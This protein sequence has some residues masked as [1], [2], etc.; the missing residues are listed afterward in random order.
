M[1]TERVAQIARKMLVS[2]WHHRTFGEGAR[3]KAA[4]TKFVCVPDYPNPT[5]PLQNCITFPV[6]T[7]Y[8]RANVSFPSSPI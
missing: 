4:A 8:L 3:P 7:S 2:T 6:S 5:I 1:T